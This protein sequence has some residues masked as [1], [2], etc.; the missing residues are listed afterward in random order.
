VGA[1]DPAVARRARH[2]AP[3]PRCH[4]VHQR[5]NRAVPA[6]LVDPGRA[7]LVREH[8]R[9]VLGEHDGAR[10][11][12]AVRRPGRAAPPVAWLSVAVRALGV[13]SVSVVG[14][15]TMPG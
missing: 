8:G 4:G 15:V 13:S 2:H 14:V 1:G 7:D 6:Q 10:G 3:R 9:A 12:L 5:R 11:V